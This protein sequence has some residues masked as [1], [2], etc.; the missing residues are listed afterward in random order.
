[1]A[2]RAGAPE[3]PWQL[4]GRRKVGSSQRATLYANTYRLPDGSTRPDYFVVDERGG[5][6]VV[7]VTDQEELVLVGQYRAPV[8]TFAWEL[9]AGAL[10]ADESDPGMRARTEL[11]EETGYEAREWHDAGVLL[12]APHRSTETDR[13]FLALG[14]RRVD[15]Q[16]LDPGESVR[17]RLV[18][19]AEV[20]PMIDRGEI[21][22]A[23]S[24]AALHKALRLRE[25]LLETGHRPSAVG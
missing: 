11:R 23:V 14:A 21:L 16:D 1:L 9:P 25:R 12:A 24:I 17:V 7:A 15:S 2:E 6:L 4:L 19:L 22:S 18:P 20:G 10:E 5:T 3:Q 13:C 8:E